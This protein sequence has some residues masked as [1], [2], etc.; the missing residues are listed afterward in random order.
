MKL[1]F[2]LDVDPQPASIFTD[3][4]NLISC[5]ANNKYDLFVIH[6]SDD[7]LM[8]SVHNMFVAVQE[9]E[10]LLHTFNYINIPV[11]IDQLIWPSTSLSYIGIRIDT[12]SM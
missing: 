1:P 8:V 7:Y 12:V 5:I 4:G 2:V 10:T 9:K 3:F 6:Y 11:T